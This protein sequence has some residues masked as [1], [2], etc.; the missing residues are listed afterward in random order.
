MISKQMATWP[1]K[2][3]E[4]M[5]ELL[6]MSERVIEQVA[7]RICRAGT[8]AQAAKPK[9]AITSANDVTMNNRQY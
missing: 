5:L 6:S 7:Q 9:P 3:F 8:V 4:S 1:E 2:W